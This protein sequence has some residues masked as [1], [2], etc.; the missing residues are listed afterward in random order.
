ML[1]VGT[2]NSTFL[3]NVEKSEVCI[4]EICKVLRFEYQPTPNVF[5]QDVRIERGWELV[6]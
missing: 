5:D 4:Y 2:K 3:Y 6:Q 1:R